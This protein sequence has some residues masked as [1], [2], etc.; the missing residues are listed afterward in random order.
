[1]AFLGKLFVAAVSLWLLSSPA[2]ARAASFDCA[3]AATPAERTICGDFE[4][5]TLDTQLAGAFAGALDRSL[6]PAE[7]RS[8][9]REWLQ[10]RNACA[11]Q[12]CLRALYRERIGTLSRMSDEPVDCSGGSTPE[13]NSCLAEYARR[14]EGELGRYFAAAR[15]RLLEEIQEDL[16]RQAP[17]DALRRLDR[18]Q[19]A[20]TAY[21]KAECEAVY[22]WWSEGTIRGA[23]YQDCMIETTKARTTSVWST[24][25]SF[26]DGSPALLPSPV[27]E[28]GETTAGAEASP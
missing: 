19:A 5:E 23:M 17:R 15:R 2:Q 4:L 12:A 1:M 25:L 8:G 20:W 27:Q 6:R 9:Q 16:E 10:A 13:V 24:W 14:A 11:D 18:S 26:P 7:L 22:D 28:R 3:K 21:R